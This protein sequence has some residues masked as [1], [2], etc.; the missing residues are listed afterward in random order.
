MSDNLYS[1]NIQGDFN[2][3]TTDGSGY[4]AFS[5]AEKN[6]TYFAYFS[7]VGGTGPELIDQTA[8][9]L[10]YLIDAQGNVV[11]PQPNSIDT[12]NMLQNFEPGKTVNVTS[13]EG[14]TLF[15]SLLGTKTI[16]DIG[17]IETILTTETGSGRI[18]YIRTMSFSQG[19]TS[20]QTTPTPDYTF[21]AKKVT[22]STVTDTTWT[23]LPFALELSDP[24]GSYDSSTYTYAFSTNTYDYSTKVIFKTSV[25]INGLSDSENFYLQIIK[26]T[27]NFLTSQSLELTLPPIPNSSYYTNTNTPTQYISSDAEG[28]FYTANGELSNTGYMNYIASIPQVFE[29]G[30]K[31]KVR[32]KVGTNTGT[33]TA[34]VTILGSSPNTLNTSFLATTNYSNTLEITSSYWLGALNFPTS[35][36]AIQGLVATLPFSNVLNPQSTFTQITPTASLALGFNS[37]TSLSHILPGDYIRF[38]Y[39]K[40]KQSKVYNVQSIP[41]GYVYLEI[42]PPV[43]SGSILDH[44]TV[45]RINPNAGNQIILNIK[46]PE[47]TTGASLTG[48]LKPQYMSKEL[49]DNFTTIIQKLAAEGTI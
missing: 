24:S 46:K 44:F 6:Q 42:N 13:L 47:G 18:D 1:T 3:S 9:F 23:D 33:G 14:T 15:S 21:S 17:R 41:G 22:S 48:F 7:S 27:D 30:S 39:D 25:L 35:S 8:Y 10:K 26:S 36:N 29:S 49:E 19:G 40:T 4:G 5:A 16:T 38:E 37:I 2:D 34:S 32:Y 20:L 11:T 45:Y 31:V 28:S 12:L 43:P